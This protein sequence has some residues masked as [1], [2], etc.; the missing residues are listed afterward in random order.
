M[1][2]VGSS[3]QTDIHSIQITKVKLHLSWDLQ[4]QRASAPKVGAFHAFFISSTGKKGHNNS[5]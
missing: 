1:P 2:R 3:C 5:T 4:Q